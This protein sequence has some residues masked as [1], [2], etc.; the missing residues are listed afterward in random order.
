MSEGSRGGKSY[1][2]IYRT[3]RRSVR[4]HVADL[5][6]ISDRSA[7]EQNNSENTVNQD[8]H[9]NLTPNSNLLNSKSTEPVIC[10]VHV[11]TLDQCATGS[12]IADRNVSEINDTV[13]GILNIPMGA[14]EVLILDSDSDHESK[15]IENKSVLTQLQEWATT[16]QASNTSLGGILKKISSIPSRTS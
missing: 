12:N 4:Q 5:Q 11:N 10:T 6:G 15:K 7:Q 16:N 1:W 8:I 14:A 9:G 13:D 3:I 2:S